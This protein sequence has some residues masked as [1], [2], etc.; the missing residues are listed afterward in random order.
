MAE[1]TSKSA[2]SRMVC[3]A[4]VKQI[5]TD[6]YEIE[7]NPGSMMEC[8]VL[9]TYDNTHGHIYGSPFKM[10]FRNV[11]QREAYGEGLATA[12]SGSW[13][14]FNVS[15]VNAGPGALWVRIESSSGEGWTPLSHASLPRY[16]RWDIGRW[17]RELTTSL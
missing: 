10:S 14:R 2:H 1:E 8:L 12:Q 7:F 6:L 13:N 15:T 4:E 16:W 3:P 5:S 17:I 9:V 11:N